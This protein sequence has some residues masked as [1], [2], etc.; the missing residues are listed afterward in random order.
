MQDA[1]VAQSFKHLTLDFDLGDDLT[2]RGAEPLIGL[3]T[4]NM[5]PAWDSLFFSLPLS[6]YL[7]M[8]K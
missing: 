5:G 4:D 3:R 7:K 2:I 6:L 8:N 1:W